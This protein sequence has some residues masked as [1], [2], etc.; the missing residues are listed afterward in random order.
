MTGCLIQNEKNTLKQINKWF[1]LG[2]YYYFLQLFYSRSSM[3][4]RC[5]QQHFRLLVDPFLGLHQTTPGGTEE[6]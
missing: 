5:F 2:R 4:N 3:C 1:W 6:H